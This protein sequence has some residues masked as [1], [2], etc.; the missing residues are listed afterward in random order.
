MAANVRLNREPARSSFKDGSH[1][2]R[3]FYSEFGEM[4]A[5]LRLKRSGAVAEVS[6]RFLEQSNIPL[7]I[8]RIEE[9]AADHGLIKPGETSIL[10]ARQIATPRFENVVFQ[11][12]GNVLSEMLNKE[13]Y[14]SRAAIATYTIDDMTCLSVEK[15]SYFT[16]VVPN[17]ERVFSI[18]VGKPQEGVQIALQ[19]LQPIQAGLKARIERVFENDLPSG[20]AR[21]PSSNGI[22]LVDFHRAISR[23]IVSESGGNSI[24]GLYSDVLKELLA[25]GYIVP[26]IRVI[27]S[28]G[29]STLLR[30]S[31]AERGFQQNGGALITPEDIINNSVRATLTPRY[32]YPLALFTLALSDK[33]IFTQ[34]YGATEK[35]FPEEAQGLE[36]ALKRELGILM[37]IFDLNNAWHSVRESEILYSILSQIFPSK[38]IS[39]MTEDERLRRAMSLY[40]P[41]KDYRNGVEVASTSKTESLEEAMQNISASLF[42]ATYGDI[43]R[44]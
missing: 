19:H 38:K 25:N 35:Y 43:I 40:V 1:A 17:G 29:R 41:A 39:A 22:S 11:L 20:F 5:L 2:A 14:S 31:M 12:V 28:S 37:P 33:V 30:K 26:E 7:T 42:K 34:R 13:G 10:Y 3:H 27:D 8:N 44:S 18:G 15:S 24:N 32:G 4:A 21:G 9:I 16:I 6:D 36:N 23:N